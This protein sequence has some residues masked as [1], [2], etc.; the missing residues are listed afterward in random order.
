MPMYV[1]HIVIASVSGLLIRSNGETNG[2]GRSS[3]AHIGV[4]DRPILLMQ[5]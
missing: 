3:A 1:C 2:T 5:H 4:T